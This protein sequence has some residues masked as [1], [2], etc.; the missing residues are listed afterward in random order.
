MERKETLQITLAQKA[1]LALHSLLK[2][3]VVIAHSSLCYGLRIIKTV[4]CELVFV[5]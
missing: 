1:L 4:T 5:E 2:T 3:N